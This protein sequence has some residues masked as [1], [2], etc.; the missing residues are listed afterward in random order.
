RERTGNSQTLVNREACIAPHRHIGNLQ[1]LNL[2]QGRRIRAKLL[3]E[4]DKTFFVSLGFNGDAGGRIQNKAADPV[5]LRQ[6]VHEGAKSDALH[7]AAKE[8]APA[9]Y[10]GMRNARHGGD[11]ER[12]LE[13]RTVRVLELEDVSVARGN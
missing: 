7:N 5:P 2:R 10:G 3:A 4:A 11:A 13:P 1:F 9:E 12:D 8:Q 6:V